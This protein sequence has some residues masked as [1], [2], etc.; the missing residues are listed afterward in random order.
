MRRKHDE[1]LAAIFRDPVSGSIRWRDVEALLIAL[2]AEMSEGNGSRVRFVLGGRTLFIHRPHPSPDTDK[3]AV[4]AVRRY[5]K[6]VGFK[7]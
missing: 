4:K 1:T 7:P 3:G 6:E 2:G 5:L